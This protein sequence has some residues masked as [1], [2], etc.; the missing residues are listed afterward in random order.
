MSGFD[1][2]CNFD[3]D[4]RKRIIW[5][6]AIPI[7]FLFQ[8]LNI[9]GIINIYRFCR[10]KGFTMSLFFIYLFSFTE[11]IALSLFMAVIYKETKYNYVQYAVYLYSKLLLGVSYQISVFELRYIIQHYFLETPYRTYDKKRKT[12][13]CIM[14]LWRLWLAASICFDLYYN[15]LRFFMGVV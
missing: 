2:S 14:N 13:K 12:A 10:L 9:L 5:A 4:K 1:C 15:Y 11:Q 6:L 3:T 8:L 7:I